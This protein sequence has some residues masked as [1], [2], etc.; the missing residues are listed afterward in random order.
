MT[1]VPA[2]L[3]TFVVVLVSLVVIGGCA[4]T[5]ARSPSGASSE[6]APSPRAL[7]RRW[8]AP[9]PDQPT[10]I[11]ADRLGAIAVG[12]YGDVAA[13]DLDGR[14]RWTQTYAHSGEQVLT[15]PAVGGDLA[16]LALSP[17]R[18]VAV[19]RPSGA[20]RWS[21]AAHDP[22][23]IDVADD[24]GSV[25][26]V[27]Y[28]GEVELLAGQ[29]GATRWSAT[30]AF[31]EAAYPSP[32]EVRKAAIVTGW[33]D[34]GGMHVEA[35]DPATGQVLWQS[36]APLFAGTPAVLS[37]SVVVAENTAIGGK[38]N[39]E[40]RVR[41]LDLRTGAEMWSRA[42]D[43]P[44]IPEVRAAVSHGVA[45]VLDRPGRM[46]GLDLDDGTVRWR[47]RTRREQYDAVPR[48][49][50]RA[51]AMLTYGT[52]LVALALRDGATV[53]NDA[54]GPVQYRVTFPGSAA[55]GGRLYL[56]AGRSRGAGEIWMLSTSLAGSSDRSPSP[57]L[58]PEV[59]RKAPTTLGPDSSLDS[60]SH[61][62]A[63]PRQRGHTQGRGRSSTTQWRA[64][65]QPEG[66]PVAVVT[67]KQLL[68][69]GVH[70]GHQTRR[71]NPKMKRFIFGERN[72]IYII[73]LQQTLERIDTAYRFV[74]RTVEDGGTVLFVGTKKQSQEPIQ[75]ES[76]RC[77]MP[78]VNYRWLGGMLTNFQTVHARVGKL[79]EFDRMISSGEAD[80]MIKKE[81]LKMR[82]ERDKLERNLGGIRQAREDPERRLRDRHEEGAHRG[83]RGEPSRHP[84]DRGR[85]HE[86]RPGRHR[87]RDPGQRRRDPL[88]E[89]DVPDHRGRG[90]RGPSARE[91]EGQG[92]RRAGRAEAGAEGVEPGGGQRRAPRS[93]RRPGT[94]PRVSRRSAR[95][96]C[97]RPRTSRSPRRAAESAAKSAAAS[98]TKDEK[99][100]AAAAVEAEVEGEQAAEA[101]VQESDRG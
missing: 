9:G 91:E 51:V 35:F 65:V 99:V 47:V 1:R 63:R 98:E 14:E 54:P 67:M 44:F 32:V 58:R 100:E 76:Q 28:G 57:D 4:T 56:V 25:A 30:L 45:I 7:D 95:S 10:G 20:M 17:G 62:P 26:V 55:V 27:G 70:F 8:V 87:L 72:G 77:N 21:A 64:E 101:E 37:S 12:R 52:G 6:R 22:Y 90:R 59:A 49:V 80:Q 60:G 48:P 3:R 2:K 18:V 79:T 94:R 71:W 66:E 5:S 78:Y 85:R 81:G 46:T 82:R 33:A 41:R 19:D 23:A 34:R 74:R 97:S 96:A 75:R 11:A 40:G 61:T 86:L 38:R 42:V 92:S 43:G 39:V 84:G 29:D 69:A 16:A 53:A 15:A 50:G 83:D 89:P 31:G 36:V 13:V 93:S 24:G 73:D 68:E 88:G